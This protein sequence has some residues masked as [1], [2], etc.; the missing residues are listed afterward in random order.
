MSDF[1]VRLESATK[2]FRDGASSV[3]AVDKA[4]ISV[5]RGKTMGIVGPSGSGKTT[6]LNMLGTLMP[7]TSGDAFFEERSV[8]RLALSEKRR[9]RLNKVGF[10]FQQLRLIQTLSVVENIMLPSVF[11]GATRD[12]R[13]KRARELVESVGLLGK[14]NRRPA[15]LSVGEQQRVAVARALVNNPI[16]VLADEPTSQLDS[17][18]GQ[19][20][21]D[22]V[23]T[24]S[25]R[26]DAAVVVSTHDQ[27][28]KERLGRIFE[29]K[30]GV[31]R[32]R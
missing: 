26:I 30:D 9:L 10:V 1:V 19:K 5:P 24:L 3:T 27:S 4:T 22:L 6:L 20:I 28:V 16:L 8:K 31:L 21:L 7:P 14:E 18:T 15:Q 2:V 13:A 32:A 11:S 29:M 17:S 12:S 25:G 23:E